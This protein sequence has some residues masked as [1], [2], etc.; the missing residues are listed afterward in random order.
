MRIQRCL[1]AAACR[2][3]CYGSAMP[4]SRQEGQAIQR[5]AVRPLHVIE[6]DQERRVRRRDGPYEAQPRELL[7]VQDLLIDS[8][9]EL[10]PRSSS[11]GVSHTLVLFDHQNLYA[12]YATDQA[13]GLVRIRL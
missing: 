11:D 1:I 8:R 10:C 6:E 3:H 12:T 5:R 2:H 4:A 9:I 7:A 13:V